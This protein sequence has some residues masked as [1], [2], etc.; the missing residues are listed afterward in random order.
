ML[1]R[2]L[3]SP[4]VRRARE[5][6]DSF[7]APGILR[8]M[9]SYRLAK[10]RSLS[11]ELIRRCAVLSERLALVCKAPRAKGLQHVCEELVELYGYQQSYR[12]D[13]VGTSSPTGL[14]SSRAASRPR[15]ASSG[16]KVDSM[17]CLARTKADCCGCCVR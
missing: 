14:W 8:L 2:P 6:S 3:C 9:A 4:K 11:N 1:L 7:I 10:T 5:G 17:Y 15:A 13:F 12:S 16:G